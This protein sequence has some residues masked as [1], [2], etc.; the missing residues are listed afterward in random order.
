MQQQQGWPRSRVRDKDAGRSRLNNPARKP[1]HGDHCST[2]R[3]FQVPVK[4][5]MTIMLGPQASPPADQFQVLVLIQYLRK[6][7]LVLKGLK[8]IAVGER[9][10]AKPTEAKQ[11]SKTLKGS[12]NQR[13]STLSG[14][15]HVTD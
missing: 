13:I 3:S 11:T 6:G 7:F 4:Q 12:D 5:S 2:R 10:C 15:D 9:L 1:F 8:L 14:S